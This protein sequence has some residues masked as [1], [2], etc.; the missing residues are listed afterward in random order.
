MLTNPVFRIDLADY[1]TNDRPH[2]RSYDCFELER[3]MLHLLP[4]V[5]PGTNVRLMV[6]NYK[7]VSDRAEWCRPDLIVQ[8]EA[9]DPSVIAAWMVVLSPEGAAA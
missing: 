9:T 8:V 6:H 1:S 3:Q 5:P 4:L 2:T 7:P